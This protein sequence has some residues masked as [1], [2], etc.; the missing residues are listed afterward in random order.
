[1]NFDQLKNA[2]L[3]SDAKVASHTVNGVRVSIRVKAKRGSY[4]NRFDYF[5]ADKRS[6]RSEVCAVLAGL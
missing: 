2:A 6:T 1:M 5:V 3:S 4:A